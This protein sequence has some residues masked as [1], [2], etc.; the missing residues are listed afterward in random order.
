MNG[1]IELDGRVVKAVLRDCKNLTLQ[2][3]KA[4]SPAPTKVRSEVD[5]LRCV[6]VVKIIL[7]LDGKPMHYKEITKKVIAS[8]LKI[9]GKTPELTINSRLS[10]SVKN[11]EGVFDAIGK[12]MYQLA[13]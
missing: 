6:D 3:K 10:V 2:L 5:R 11:G 8:G 13:S 4:A 1:R 7:R 9:S 12:G